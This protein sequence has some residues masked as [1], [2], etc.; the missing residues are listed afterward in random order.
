VA[1][2]DAAGRPG[3]PLGGYNCDTWSVLPDETVLCD[4]D[5]Q[6]RSFSVR[7]RDGSVRYRVHASGD[8]QLLDLVLSPDA[9]HVAYAVAGG[10]PIVTDATGRNVTLPATFRPTGWLDPSTLVGAVQTAQGDGD[11]ALVRLDAPAK[12]DDL[13][14]RGFFVGVVQGS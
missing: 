8:A 11:L 4:D 7:G 13:G 14:F 2:L 3:P 12:I 6:L 5:G 10:R 9:A 1:E